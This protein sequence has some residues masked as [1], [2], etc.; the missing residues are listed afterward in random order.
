MKDSG[1]GLAT[2]AVDLYNP[3]PLCADAFIC[4]K[5]IDLRPGSEPVRRL[6]AE[7]G[8]C[9]KNCMQ[10]HRSTERNIVRRQ[11]RVC[12]TAPEVGEVP[13][14]GSRHVQYGEPRTPRVK[15]MPVDR[16]GLLQRCVFLQTVVYDRVCLTGCIMK[17]DIIEV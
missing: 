10:C 9:S 5:I 13:L 3:P 8:R 7:F 17:A 12:R 15:L 2:E 11:T 4:A 14:C 16:F 1:F 6:V